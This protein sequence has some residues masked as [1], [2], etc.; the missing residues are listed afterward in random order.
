MPVVIWELEHWER[1]FF[2]RQPNI[3]M[4]AEKN[5]RHAQSS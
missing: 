3:T 5:L 1:A 4:N 2:I